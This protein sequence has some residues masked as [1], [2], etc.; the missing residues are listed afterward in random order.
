[1]SNNTS[2]DPRWKADRG[3]GAWAGGEWRQKISSTWAVAGP[4]PLEH[5]TSAIGP[6]NDSRHAPLTRTP[7][8]SSGE[9][10]VRAPAA[11]EESLEKMKARAKSFDFFRFL[12]ILKLYRIG[13]RGCHL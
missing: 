2:N 13:K 1:M 5:V 4:T 6:E 12:H 10:T 11:R 7:W 8:W 9:Q 3:K